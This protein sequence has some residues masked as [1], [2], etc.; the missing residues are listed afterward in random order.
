MNQLP[1]SIMIRIILSVA[2]RERKAAWHLRNL[3][4]GM[5]LDKYK[6]AF[7]LFDRALNKSPDGPLAEMDKLM[8]SG[9]KSCSKKEYGAFLKK[10]ISEKRFQAKLIAYQ[11][12]KAVFEC[13]EALSI[14]RWA[15]R[16]NPADPLTEL[17][18]IMQPEN[19]NHNLL[20]K[21]LM[22]PG[23]STILTR[24]LQ[25]EE[26][27]CYE[28]ELRAIF[29]LYPRDAVLFKQIW[30]NNHSIAQLQAS[31]A[32]VYKVIGSRSGNTLKGFTYAMIAYMKLEQEFL[33]L[34]TEN[35]FP[36]AIRD[37]KDQLEA[38]FVHCPSIVEGVGQAWRSNPDAST[39]Q[40]QKNIEHLNLDPLNNCEK[41]FYRYVEGVR[42]TS[43]HTFTDAIIEYTKLEQQL[44]QRPVSEPATQE[45]STDSV[46]S[47]KGS[48][49]SIYGGS[50]HGGRMLQF[51]PPRVVPKA[52]AEEATIEDYGLNSK[53]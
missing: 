5:R 17:N 19:R 10:W 47:G 25:A 24:Y 38:A 14:F 15:Y 4:K 49:K 20:A 31:L 48:A 18:K 51:T 21:V 43:D 26:I 53:L 7:A 46:S 34:R 27:F 2:S 35:I 16:R 37:Y 23:S 29:S 30:Q 44:L 42:T 28:S 6:N 22:I 36:R 13:E 33:Q 45:C 40:L 32:E 9:D 39:A 50:H 52:T 12:A 3:I 11:N 41:I 8:Q 1:N